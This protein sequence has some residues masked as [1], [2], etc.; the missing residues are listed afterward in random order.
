MVATLPCTSSAGAGGSFSNM[1]TSRAVHSF[2][3]HLNSTTLAS[4]VGH[5]RWDHG[6]N[7]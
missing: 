1:P 2:P 6:D 5:F 4:R 3:S 7:D